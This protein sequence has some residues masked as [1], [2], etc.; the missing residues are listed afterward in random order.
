MRNRYIFSIVKWNAQFLKTLVLSQK[1]HCIFWPAA[2]NLI[3][4][5]SYSFVMSVVALI[6]SHVALL[7]CLFSLLIFCSLHSV[8]MS[9]KIS[10]CKSFSFFFF[11]CSKWD[12][13]MIWVNVMINYTSTQTTV[14]SSTVLNQFKTR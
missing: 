1:N 9:K 12:I 7:L 6:S 8:N 2:F 10:L 11:F 14:N 13:D 3:D 5:Y 4:L